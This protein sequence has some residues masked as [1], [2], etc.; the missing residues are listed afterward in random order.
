MYK[1]LERI[2]KHLHKHPELSTQEFQ[3]QAYVKQQLEKLNNDGL[4][5]MGKT[6]LVVLFKGKDTGKHILLRADM[7]ALPIQEVNT[8]KHRSVYEGVSHK[9]GHDGHTTILLGVAQALSKNPPER[10]EVCLVFQPAEENGKGAR[11]ILEDPA[12]DF[13]AD[14]AVALHNLPGYPLHEVVC[15]KHNFN[16]AARSVILKLHGKT[17]HAAE[18]ETGHNP[19]L[20]IAEIIQHSESLSKKSIDAPDFRLVSHIYLNMGEQA[21]GVSAGY[22]EVH[23]T[24]RSWTNDVM[25]TLV[26]EIEEGVQ[27]IA[28]KH[29]LRLEKEWLEVFYANMNDARA[30]A[31]IR[32]SAA[33][34]ELK[35]TERLQ[36]FKW[37]EDFGLFTEQ[38]PGAM[39]GIGSGENCPALHNPDYDY[40]DAITPTA[41]N[42]FLKILEK[43]L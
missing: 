14:M 9:C 12:F 37:G 1:A 11:A 15:R 33:D 20:A 32:E 39:F 28:D 23:L 31:Y 41:V 7:D 13:K 43:A 42:M 17:A 38:F 34:L 27:T 35:Y 25:D 6:G 10:G 18:P 4:Y 3:T 8:F 5:E 26:K 19:A 24:L 36:P 21:Y 40:P 2:R 22:G 30:Y 29:H 16:A